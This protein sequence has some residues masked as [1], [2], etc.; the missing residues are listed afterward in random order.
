M[1]TISGDTLKRLEKFKG[2]KPET[3]AIHGGQSPD[4][5][6]GAVMPPIFLTSTYAQKEP[7]IPVGEFEYSRTHN[8]TR[9]ML[10][11]C[12]ALLE[13]GTY[14]YATSSG[15]NAVTLIMSL[16]KQGDEVLCCD[17]VY[18]GTYR[19]FTKLLPDSGLS[20][21]FADFTQIE[22][23]SSF[24]EKL[25]SDK[26]RM[27]WVESPTNPLLKL[28]DIEAIA[29]VCR[30]KGW[31]L[32]VD[33]TFM[34]PIFQSPLEL[35]ADIVMHSMTKYMS[36]HSDIVAGALV[37]K[38]KDLAEKLYFRQ[39]SQGAMCS[40]FDAWM[41]MRSLKTL[42]VRMK[43]H[44]ENALNLARWME[45]DSRFEKV[46]YPGLE[47][48]KQHALAKKQMH[49]FGGMISAY[50]RGDLTKTKKLLSR[51]KIFTL[52]ESLGGVESL[53]EHP[54]I[55]THASLPQDVRMQL[56]I[57]DNFIRLSVGL[58]NIED[59]K[60]DLIQAL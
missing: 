57:T 45:N 28:I 32:V 41:V 13:R 51:V 5:T 11:D 23:D 58:E 15:M 19:I 37:T 39:N 2:Q 47:S 10:E 21:K 36:G 43:A 3:L 46:I 25:S 9:R 27:V 14:G 55:M 50:V 29:K 22:K 53:I 7:G 26:T 60:A 16:L 44:Q 59:I 18:G 48:H 34:S 38:N 8:P 42:P 4:P 35:G 24:L 54:G 1:T 40:P 30:R 33:N 6:T 52:A 56:G 17:D 49:G 20:F 12:I 31:I